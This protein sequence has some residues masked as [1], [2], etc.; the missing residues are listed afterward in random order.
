MHLW[1]PAECESSAYR[2]RERAGSSRSEGSLTEAYANLK[3]IEMP[4]PEPTPEP[5]PEPEPTPTRAKM[6]RLQEQIKMIRLQEQ[7]KMIRLQ[8]QAKI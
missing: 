3:L 5:T 1:Q 8:E 7:I 6:I 4:E 2:S